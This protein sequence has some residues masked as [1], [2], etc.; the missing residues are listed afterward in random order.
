MYSASW[1]KKYE[2]E[3]K[4]L[5]LTA[6]PCYYG[7]GNYKDTDGNLWDVKCVF[8]GMY[9]ASGKPYVCARLVTDSPYYSTGWDSNQGGFHSWKP[10]YFEVVKE[11]VEVE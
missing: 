5:K 8:G 11:E 3:V 1:F 9:T 7:L 2:G 4:T 10:Y 6:D